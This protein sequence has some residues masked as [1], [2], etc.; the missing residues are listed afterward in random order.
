MRSAARL[1]TLGGGAQI[2][3]LENLHPLWD[4]D[5]ASTPVDHAGFPWR[6]FA[7]STHI[8]LGRLRANRGNVNY[9]VPNDADTDALSSVILGCEG[10]IHRMAGRR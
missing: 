7:H 10:M 2:L 3:R 5:C 1:I 4:H 9:A 8:D 6:K